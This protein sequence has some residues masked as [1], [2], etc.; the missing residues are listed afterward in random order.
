DGFVF[1]LQTRSPKETDTMAHLFAR[2][3]RSNPPV[4]PCRR[5]ARLELE[6]L[7]ERA[8][9]SGYAQTNLTGFQPG[10]ARPTDPPLNGWGLAFAPDG[11][12]CV[13]DTATGVATFY[14][15]LGRPLP[16]VIT[17][18]AA[19]GQP[20]GPVGTPTGIVYNPTPDFVISAHGRSAPARFLFDTL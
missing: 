14:G 9:P 12:F 3:K 10:M 16:P 5:R 17:I 13:A 6:R 19:P 11:P 15:R 1:V 2:P 20:L 8:L 7:E 4:A 18:P